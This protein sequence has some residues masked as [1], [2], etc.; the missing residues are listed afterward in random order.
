MANYYKEIN[1]IMEKITHKFLINDRKG[2]KLGLKG[3]EFSI[4]DMHI[5]KTIGKNNIIS[6]Y[7][8]VEYIEIDRGVI[9]S[10]LNKMTKWGYIE[11]EKSEED[12]RV[13]NIML[14]KEGHRIY[15]DIL[16]EEKE[17]LEFVLEDI[18]LNEE[19][20]ILKFFSKLNQRI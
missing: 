16:K 11:K 8:L 18:S 10:I 3:E 9:T 17:L 14:T 19:K 12:K 2:F 13:Y 4:L 1:K 15:D 7:K 20:A 5:I 6:L